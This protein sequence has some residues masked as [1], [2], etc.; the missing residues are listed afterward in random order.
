LTTLRLA[1]ACTEKAT[2]VVMIAPPSTP[3]VQRSIT[4]RIPVEVLEPRWKYGDLGAAYRLSRIFRDQQID[5]VVLMQSRDIH[6]VSLASLFV[7]NLKSVFYQQMDSGYDKR[8]VFHSWVYSKVSL[9]LSLTEGMKTNVLK[10]TR[11]SSR[12]VDVLPLG[13]DLKKFNP[14]KHSKAAAR[15]HCGLPARGQLIGVLGRLDPQKGQEVLLRALPSVLRKHPNVHVVLA[16]D[17][18]A[19]EPGYKA[20]L[21]KVCSTLA[22][23]KHVAFLPFTEDVPHLLAALDL[24][25]LPSYCETYG[26]VVIEAMAMKCPVIATNAG[27]VPEIIGHGKTGLL[28]EPRKENQLARAIRR[29]LSDKDFRGRVV[30]A[31]RIDALARFDF[32][33][34]V[35]RFLG[36]LSSL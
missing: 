23:D 36:F 22:I 4:S 15:R 1:K 32:N 10:Y 6:L 18:T 9:W 16:G 14:A 20:H 29:L 7:K 8:D 27:G 12:N 11:M 28:V 24:F 31:A 19:G 17:E 2:G 30:R 3:L 21:Q 35:D 26:L 33:T 5:I 13:I 34:T 25:V